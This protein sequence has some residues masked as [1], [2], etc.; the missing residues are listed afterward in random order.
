MTKL[1][2]KPFSL[3]TFPEGAIALFAFTGCD[4]ERYYF[5][6]RITWDAES[7]AQWGDDYHGLGFPDVTHYALFEGP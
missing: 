6:D 7:P 5:V 3:D 2:W 1:D 4:G